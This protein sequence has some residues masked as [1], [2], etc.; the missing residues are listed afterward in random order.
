MESDYFY[1]FEV[2]YGVDIFIHLLVFFSINMGYITR[3][4]VKYFQDNVSCCIDFGIFSNLCTFYFVLSP[5]H[6]KSRSYSTV[7]CDVP[8]VKRCTNDCAL[9]SN[10]C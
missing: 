8:I 7:I 9:L 2:M 10:N 3:Q 5:I 4:V 1:Y 6:Q